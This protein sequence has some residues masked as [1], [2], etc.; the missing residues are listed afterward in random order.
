MN[1]EDTTRG[2]VTEL[3]GMFG[4]A[5][6]TVSIDEMNHAIAAWGALARPSTQDA[7]GVPAVSEYDERHVGADEPPYL[8]EKYGVI[9]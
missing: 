5:G 9:K 7:E 1:P 2:S 4:R 6:R 8:H 3:K